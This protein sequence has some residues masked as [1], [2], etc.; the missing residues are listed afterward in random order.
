MVD[1]SIFREPCRLALGMASLPSAPEP[2]G[3]FAQGEQL[4]RLCSR[5][6]SRILGCGLSG[7]NPRTSF[8][9]ASFSLAGYRDLELR[10]KGVVER[11]EQNGAGHLGRLF[12]AAW[13]SPPRGFSCQMLPCSLQLPPA[14]KSRAGG[15]LV[16][17]GP[18]SLFWGQARLTNSSGFALAVPD[19]R[20][21]SAA[22]WEVL[23]S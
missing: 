10:G 1:F 16:T 23:E 17:S 5:D 11:M 20:T 8:P 21:E 4:R 9:L 15:R 3:S 19:F 7:R 13:P 2:Q 12:M 6:V 18:G 14:A 22:S